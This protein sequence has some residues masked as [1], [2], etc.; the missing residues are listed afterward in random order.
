M[1]CA[2]SAARYAR[3]KFKNVTFTSMLFTNIYENYTI[4]SSTHFLKKIF[5]C[6]LIYDNPPLFLGL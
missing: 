1:M 3:S 6:T 2:G 4:A 5:M